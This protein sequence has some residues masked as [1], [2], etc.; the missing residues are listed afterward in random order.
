MRVKRRGNVIWA[1]I[2]NSWPADIGVWNNL[3][4]RFNLNFNRL[5]S[6]SV[7]WHEDDG[8]DDN[9]ENGEEDIFYPPWTN[10]LHK[11]C[12][13]VKVKFTRCPGWKEKWWKCMSE[14]VFL[15][16]LIFLS[17]FDFESSL[18]LSLSFSLRCSHRHQRNHC[19]SSSGMQWMAQWSQRLFKWW[20]QECTFMALSLSLSL[21][22]LS[23]TIWSILSSLYFILHSKSHDSTLIGASIVYLYAYLYLYSISSRERGREKERE[24]ERE[25]GRDKNNPA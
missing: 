23:V 4:K 10:I 13:L 19:S 7:Q 21:L 24:G 9:V 14:C 1:E 11:M 18:S 5:T 17:K 22:V 6:Q 3:M 8:G 12:V 16:Q 15:H 2:K 25:E 20:I